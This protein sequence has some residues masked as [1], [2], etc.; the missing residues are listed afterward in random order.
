MTQVSKALAF[1]NVWKQPGIYKCNTLIPQV[2]FVSKL[3]VESTGFHVSC[4]HRRRKKWWMKCSNLSQWKAHEW[5][6]R[7]ELCVFFY[8]PF[9]CILASYVLYEEIILAQDLTLKLS[10]TGMEWF[11]YI[12]KHSF[13]PK[14]FTIKVSVGI[15]SWPRLTS[16]P[17]VGITQHTA[18][19]P[20]QMHP[21]YSCFYEWKARASRIQLSPCA[22]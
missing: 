5:P 22:I 15:G 8:H 10:P 4:F 19:W 16:Q 21:W 20:G 7:Q 3:N 12:I 11:I 2:I 6:T 9:S 13:P 14:L 1:Q 18:R 17:W